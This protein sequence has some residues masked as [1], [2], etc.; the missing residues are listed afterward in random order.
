MSLEGYIEDLGV[1]DILQILSLS[2]KSG[3]LELRSRR[4]EG[5]ISFSEGHVVRATSSRF[6]EGLGQLLCRE[7]IV[8][9]EQVDRA[10][11]YQQQLKQHKPLGRILV[12]LFRIP[13][14][15]IEKI[16]E[17]QIE[18]IVFSF[19]SWQ[20]GSFLFRLEKIQQFG[21]AIVNPLD[22]M[23]ERGLSPQR[24]A[25]KGQKVC[26]EGE[27]EVDDALIDREILAVQTR[28]QQQ[29]IDLLRGMLAELEHPEFCGGIILLILRYASEIME[30]AII[31]D[32][33]DSDLVGLGQFGLEAG[34]GSADELIRK[35]KLKIEQGSV[36]E[37]VL[38]K[39]NA[40]TGRLGSTPSEQVLKNI[41]DRA[42]SCFVAPLINDGDVV[43]LLYGDRLLTGRAPRSCEAF[44]V[45]LSQAGLALEQALQ[46]RG[47]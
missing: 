37:Q 45:F 8:T 9:A 20:E 36:F 32:V 35:M 43:A 6:P 40:V 24:L 44:E 47:C 3:T 25:I 31:F 26:S 29:G 46:G 10:L 16:V 4:E 17:K 22:F 28:Q 13:S 11:D 39:K 27:A 12:D 7:D 33:R 30:R 18:R 1:C 21:S 5:M 2:K 23:L 15:T 41:L 19:F 34:G 14:T 38:K 42:D